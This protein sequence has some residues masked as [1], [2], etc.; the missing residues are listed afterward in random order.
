VTKRAKNI[1]LLIIV[2]Q[3]FSILGFSFSQEIILRTGEEVILETTP[4]DPRDIFR[5]EYVNLRYGISTLTSDQCCFEF[6][7]HDQ[8]EEVDYGQTIYVYLEP[9]EEQWIANKAST[10]KKG[11]SNPAHV[12]IR[13]KITSIE[14]NC[15]NTIPDDTC[16]EKEYSI[17]YGIESYF[18]PEGK[19][20]EIE[21]ANEL[22]VIARVNSRGIAKISNL[23]V[24]GELWK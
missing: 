2:I 17:D 14:S 15:P 19:G 24:N 18:V 10:S 6:L 4:V 21:Q 12:L 22:K 9:F 16:K 23:I 13:G 3:I 11:K 20:Q 8:R 1:F 7:E 5:G